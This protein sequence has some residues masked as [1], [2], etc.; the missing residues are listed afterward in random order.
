MAVGVRHVRLEVRP[1]RMVERPEFARLQIGLHDPV[2]PAVHVHGQDA[3]GVL[4][5]VERDQVAPQM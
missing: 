3:G 2:D 1:R 5:P 4:G